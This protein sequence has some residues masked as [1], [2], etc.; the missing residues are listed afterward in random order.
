M[1]YF[2]GRLPLTDKARARRFGLE[3]PTRA[4]ALKHPAI[5]K[6]GLSSLVAARR[7][8]S[9]E[10]RSWKRQSRRECAEREELSRYRPP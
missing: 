10:A 5:R 1:S 8:F 2:A 3:H 4:A 7:I 6:F 9:R